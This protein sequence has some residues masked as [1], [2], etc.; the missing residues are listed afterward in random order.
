MEDD[1]MKF[2][3][4]RI[5]MDGEIKSFNSMTTPHPSQEQKEHEWRNGSGGEGIRG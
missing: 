1:R 4:F 3:T 2:L 5:W